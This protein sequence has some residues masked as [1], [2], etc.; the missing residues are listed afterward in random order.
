MEILGE[1]ITIFFEDGKQVSRKSGK[2][3]NIEWG[4]TLN[5]EDIIPLFRIV[6]IKKMTPQEIAE[7]QKA[8]EN[9]N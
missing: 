5:N 1:Y 4:I 6:R 3:I 8:N 9:D 2:V 7:Y